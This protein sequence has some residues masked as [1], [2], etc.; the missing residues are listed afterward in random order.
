MKKHS[1]SGEK[2]SLISSL[3]EAKIPEIDPLFGSV[4]TGIQW[5]F[6]CFRGFFFP[7]R[8]FWCQLLQGEGGLRENCISP[9]VFFLGSGSCF[10]SLL[11][12]LIWKSHC[13]W[14]AFCAHSHTHTRK[15]RLLFLSKPLTF[16]LVS[17]VATSKTYLLESCY[18]PFASM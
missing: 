9:R 12:G 3:K 15:I 4:E 10:L 11:F 8:F 14:R 5:G 7:R 1:I 6:K 18:Y 13:I 17:S 16:V 2:S